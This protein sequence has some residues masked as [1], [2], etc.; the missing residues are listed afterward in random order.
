MRKTSQ[1]PV[2]ERKK[3]LKRKT[4]YLKD[5]EFSKF[6]KIAHYAKAWPL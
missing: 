2:V 1:Q 4:Q 6:G 3:R 5:D